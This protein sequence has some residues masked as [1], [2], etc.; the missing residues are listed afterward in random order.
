VERERGQ[1]ERRQRTATVVSTD[2]HCGARIQD[3]KPYLEARYH[4]EFDAW[5]ASYHYPWADVDLDRP[6]NERRGPA[7]FNAPLSWES[8]ERLTYTESQGNAEILFPNTA[9]PFIPSGSISAPGPRSREEYEHRMA[10]LRAHNRWLAEFCADAPGRRAGIAQIFLDDVGAAV[11]EVRWAKDAGL[12]GVLLPA[13]HTLKMANLYCPWFDAFW[14]A[15]ADLEMPVH[16]HGV[17]QCESAAEGGDAAPWVSRIEAPFYHLRAIPHMLTAEVF[18]KFPKL[19]FVTTEALVTTTLPTLLK[20]LDSMYQSAT[21]GRTFN[22]QTM[23]AAHK[24]TRKPSQAYAAN[25]YLGGPMDLRATY[26]AGTPN[27]M[28]GAD[29]PHSEGTSPFTAEALRVMLSGL[30]AE[31]I[32]KIAGLTAMDVYG[33]DHDLLRSVAERVG[34]TLA[35]VQTPLGDDEWPRF[36]KDTRCLTFARDTQALVAPSASAR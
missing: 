26:E 14:E 11:E 8:A 31:D 10:G 27:L 24:L 17:T 7:S 9:P 34:P 19:R 25:C 12:M 35:Q 1:C 3:Y 22:P 4:D 33:F 29:L 32:R 23:V 36:P 2:G 30:P 15:C 5:A 28:F 6:P 21:D 16:R 20:T 18:D 13:D